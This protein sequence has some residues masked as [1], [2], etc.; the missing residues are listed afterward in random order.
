M[1]A[2]HVGTEQYD[3]LLVSNERRIRGHTV[4]EATRRW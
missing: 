4:I 1:W 3:R 2:H